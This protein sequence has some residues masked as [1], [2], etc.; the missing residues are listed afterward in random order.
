MQGELCALCSPLLSARNAFAERADAEIC[1]AKLMHGEMRQLQHRGAFPRTP[2]TLSR[3]GP[4]PTAA[5]EEICPRRWPRRSICGDYDSLSEAYTVEAMTQSAGWKGR[6]HVNGELQHRHRPST[7]QVS[8]ASVHGGIDCQHATGRSQPKGS[9]A[10]SD[11]KS[12][13]AVY[14][15]CATCP[16]LPFYDASTI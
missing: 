15:S 11:C 16:T 7:R 4:P 13:R 6:D 3:V 9:G 14:N 5:L 8:T 12:V 10:R 1:A 2:P